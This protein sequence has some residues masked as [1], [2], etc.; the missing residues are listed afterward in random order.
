MIVQVAHNV[1]T[2]TLKKY[3]KRFFQTFFKLV[4]FSASRL[5]DLTK[6]EN[7]CMINISKSVYLQNSFSLIDINFE[8]KT[9]VI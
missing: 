2:I 6:T 1:P 3:M 4:L 5:K 7:L 8:P 9:S